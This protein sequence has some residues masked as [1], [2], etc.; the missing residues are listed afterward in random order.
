MKSMFM[1]VMSWRDVTSP[2]ASFMSLCI[3]T[4]CFSTCAPSSPNR[5]S[6][7]VCG[8]HVCMYVCMYLYNVLQ[9]LRTFFTKQNFGL[10]V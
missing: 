3:S 2:S 6:A 1:P 4:T 8:M 9:H 7:S 5:T 10:C